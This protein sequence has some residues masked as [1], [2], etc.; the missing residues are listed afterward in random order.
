[1]RNKDIKRFEIQ[2]GALI[3]LNRDRIVLKAQ[4]GDFTHLFFVDSDMCFDAAILE[5]LISRDKDIIGTVYNFRKLPIEPII[6]V[7][8]DDG[9]LVPMKKEDIPKDLFKVAV[10]GIGC[11]L[12]KLDVFKKIKRPWFFYEKF[13]DKNEGMG[14]DTWFCKK[15]REAGYDIFVDPTVII[16]HVGNMVY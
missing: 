6:R 13:D 9:K 11:M 10:A 16:G 8:D 7:T 2:Q 3:H 5:R 14:E 12:I 1:M 4:Q 15:A